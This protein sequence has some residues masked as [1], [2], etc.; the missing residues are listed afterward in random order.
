MPILPGDHTIIVGVKCRK[1]VLPQEVMAGNAKHIMFSDFSVNTIQKRWEI[2]SISLG[3][4][5]VESSKATELSGVRSRHRVQQTSKWFK[6]CWDPQML[7]L[8]KS[9]F[10]NLCKAQSA[11]ANLIR[12]G[13]NES[14]AVESWPCSAGGLVFF[15]QCWIVFK[16]RS[17]FK[18]PSLLF[19]FL[20]VL[21]IF[22]HTIA[23]IIIIHWPRCNPSM[24]LF[25]LKSQPPSSYSSDEVLHGKKVSIQWSNVE[26]WTHPSE[27][28]T[29]LVLNIKSLELVEKLFNKHEMHAIGSKFDEKGFDASTSC[30][31]W[32]FGASDCKPH[33]RSQ[34]QC[35][36]K[37]CSLEETIFEGTLLF[38]K[39][40][41][42][43]P[44]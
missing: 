3:C 14:C 41:R 15:I 21:H 28:K 42:E 11:C 29:Y 36:R 16:R 39:P 17:S 31:N 24:Q 26:R 12:T 5:F 4:M 38:K 1:R 34:R 20:F 32:I 6:L 30:W 37:S 23:I 27:R 43:K 10:T 44:F 8:G 9:A 25:A 13:F 22:L 19:S 40:E 7:R 33:A 35:K 18:F 2:M